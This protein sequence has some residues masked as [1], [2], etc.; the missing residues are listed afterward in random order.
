LRKRYVVPDSSIKQV[1][2][3]VVEFNGIMQ[4]YATSCDPKLLSI[5]NQIKN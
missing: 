2:F 4:I 1:V 3:G 5:D